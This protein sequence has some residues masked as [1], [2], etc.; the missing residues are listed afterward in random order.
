M[1]SP[2]RG[3]FL[4]VFLILVFVLAFI[5]VSN[6]GLKER[7][8]PWSEVLTSAESGLSLAR[9]STASGASVSPSRV[10]GALSGAP[11][12]STGWKGMSPAA[13]KGSPSRRSANSAFSAMTS[14]ATER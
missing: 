12:G 6:E 9:C 1:K 11:E 13:R 14:G 7:D 3:L 5:M 8:L 2:S 10:S 4:W